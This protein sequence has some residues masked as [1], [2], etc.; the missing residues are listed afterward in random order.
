MAGTEIMTI[1]DLSV[2]EVAVEVNENDI[3]RVGIND[4]TKI[5]VDAYL[6]ESFLGIVTEIANSANVTGISA[7]QVTNFD[8]KIRM[9]QSSYQK[10]SDKM[11]GNRSP[12]RPGMSA[13]VDIRT[14][15]VN[16]VITV[17][18]QAVTT[19]KDSVMKKSEMNIEDAEEELDE[20][21]FIIEEGKAKKMIV[22]TGIQ[23]TMYIE[24]TSGLSD[25][26]EVVTGPYSLISKRL[27]DGDKVNVVDKKELFTKK[28]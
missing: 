20:V 9:L 11:K 23:N 13:T 28:K 3:V 7:D 1:A 5:E 14:M 26:Q 2:M 15:A 25:G 27:K 4:T 6:D 18:I 17:P 21:V 19:R 22:E 10:L 8:V 12:F 16:N 24:V